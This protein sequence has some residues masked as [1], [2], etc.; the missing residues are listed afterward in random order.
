MKG[1]KGRAHGFPRTQGPQQEG[2]REQEELRQPDAP[3]HVLAAR[4]QP[5]HGPAVAWVG[6]AGVQG[7]GCKLMPTIAPAA[8]LSWPANDQW[9]AMCY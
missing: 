9:L 2:A 4:A 8:F 3:H 6:Q 5:R 1:T 7:Q